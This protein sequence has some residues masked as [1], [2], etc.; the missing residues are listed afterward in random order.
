MKTDERCTGRVQSAVLRPNNRKRFRVKCDRNQ[1]DIFVELDRR[2]SWRT[3]RAMITEY[4]SRG[5]KKQK[6]KK[7]SSTIRTMTVARG[8]KKNTSGDGTPAATSTRGGHVVAESSCARRT[9]VVRRRP[10]GSV[11]LREETISDRRRLSHIVCLVEWSLADAAAVRQR[12]RVVSF[13]ERLVDSNRVN[14]S[15]TSSAAGR[16]RKTPRPVELFCVY[17]FKCFFLLCSENNAGFTAYVGRSYRCTPRTET[18]S[19]RRI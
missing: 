14:P 10:F 1:T 6:K 8:G 12:R 11:K 3:R 13:R 17:F 5:H 7:P 9:R 19:A 4:Q 16:E 18:T 15:V 2:L